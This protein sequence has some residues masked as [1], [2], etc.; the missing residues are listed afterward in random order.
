MSGTGLFTSICL[1]ILAKPSLH[2]FHG[3][4]I[5]FWWRTPIFVERSPRPRLA[6]AIRSNI[7]EGL[8]KKEQNVGS[9]STF[10]SFAFL[11]S[12]SFTLPSSVFWIPSM[13]CLLLTQITSYT[14]WIKSES[15][16]SDHANGDSHTACH[17]KCPLLANPHSINQGRLAFLFRQ[18]LVISLGV[19]RAFGPFDGLGKN[20]S[21]ILV[22]WSSWIQKWTKQNRAAEQIVRIHLAS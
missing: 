15:D 3:F 12:L 22:I 17:V 4:S 9:F 5:I 2:V 13:M 10:L 11:D 7:L 19:A 20:T 16:K 8:L 1:P 21:E 6:S 14:T 18:I